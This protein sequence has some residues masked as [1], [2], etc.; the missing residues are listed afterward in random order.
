[1]RA[2]CEREFSSQGIDF[3][4]LQAN[5]SLSLL[6]GTIRG[7]HYQTEPALEAKLVRCTRGT[8]FDVV[9]D[10][11][12]SSATYRA[13]HGEYLSADNGRMFFVPEGCAHGCQAL[14]DVSEIHYLTSAVYSP[15]NSRGV[16]YD[17]P[18]IG[19][20]WPLEMISNFGPGPQLAPPRSRA[21]SEAWRYD[22]NL[23]GNLDPARNSAIYSLLQMRESEQRPI[24]VGVIGA[25]ATSRAIALQLGTP[26]AGMRL[27]GI[28][29]RTPEHA[30]R[31]F[32][33]AG[34]CELEDG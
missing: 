25:G 21:R 5:M 1:M 22:M 3:T 15:N 11:R 27:A 12:P 19:I 6:K 28:S 9:V 14:E 34:Y 32:K 20:A 8:M 2:W 7:L 29:N 18:A 10:L 4:P 26:V 30:E 17:D 16:R 23:P 13:W 24:R 31:A 33:E